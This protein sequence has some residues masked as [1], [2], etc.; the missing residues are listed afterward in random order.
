MPGLLRVVRAPKVAVGIG[1]V[2]FF[3]LVA[4]IGPFV[5]SG[6]PTAT[7]DLSLQG[8]SGAHWLGTTQTGEDVFTQ[9]VYGARVSLSV[10]ALSAVV[11]TTLAVTIGLIAG[12][13]RGFVDDALSALTSVFLVIPAMPLLI[14][15][16][17]YLPNKGIESVAVV[18]SV[19]AWASGAR[20]IRAQTLSVRRRDFVEAARATGERGWRII[21]AE[22]LPNEIPLLASS[23]LFSIVVGILAEAG[24]SFLGLGSLTTVSWGSMLYFAQNAEA[25]ISGAWWWFIPPGLC[26]A[27]VGTGLAL[28]NFGIDE[29]ANP[30]LRGYRKPPKRSRRAATTAGP[31]AATEDTVLSVRD[32]EVVY[33]TDSGGVRAVEGVSLEL[34]RGEV[35]G[36]AG[37]SGSGKSTMANAVARLL[38]S[39]AQVT[40]GSVT[41]YRKDPAEPAVDILD[42][43]RAALQQFR[44]AELAVVFQS[45]MN[46]LNPVLSV[47]AQFDD[48]L[49][50]HRPDMSARVRRTRAV[51]LLAR[52]GITED[53]L[54][55]FPH[56]LS[57]GM[58]QRVAIAIAL[59]LDPDIIIMDEPTT[60]LD[61]VV[62]RDILRQ[63][64]EL[65]QE[66][67]FAVVFI[68]HDLSLLLEI[69]DRIAIMYAGR[70][71]E[72]APAGQIADHPAHPY[73][74][75]LLES[76]PRLHGP[77][78]ELT[79]IPGT[80]PD[81]SAPIQ[82][83][84]FADRCAYA[85]EPCTSV[86]PPPV[87]PAAHPVACLL[88]DPAH[89]DGP[90]PEPVRGADSAADAD[91]RGVRR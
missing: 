20:V 4:I 74:R 49:R 56:E 8:P 73:T 86:L 62:Q 68:T 69:C 81:L 39:P 83:C 26:V 47:H 19:T 57:G 13:S 23:L 14:V 60:A 33:H 79:G 30:R 42:L 25:L 11:A 51:E 44:W 70:I 1:I 2:G 65:R 9:L 46:S 63:I 59:A 22:I 50:A 52:V 7:S 27:L 32:L 18:I 76:F 29:F 40:A 58:R 6:S 35:L 78:R 45:A 89:H 66:Y 38:R 75:G 72:Q 82:G 53:R 80:P 54:G 64:L 31:D 17:G 5:I 15:L 21:F 77:Q 55:S 12:Y 85:F 3:V 88:H 67:G 37:E 71:V 41:F 84:A 61:V 24:L 16:A 90:I 48:V 28:V 10:G 36:L 43:D 91:A 87:G 34:R